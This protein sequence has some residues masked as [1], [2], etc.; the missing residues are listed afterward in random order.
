MF[1]KATAD[2]RGSRLFFFYSL[3]CTAPIH[4]HVN[5]RC[6]N[7]FQSF[8][9]VFSIDYKFDVFLTGWLLKY[10]YID[11]FWF[12]CEFV[13]R[14]FACNE[15]TV[16]PWRLMNDDRCVV[17]ADTSPSCVR[18]HG[19]LT[20]SGAAWRRN[21]QPIRRMSVPSSLHVYYNWRGR[22]G[23]SSSNLL[24]WALRRRLVSAGSVATHA[25]LF[26]SR[27]RD[28]RKDF[29]R[30]HAVPLCVD[31]WR[32]LSGR[33]R[34]IRDVT[35]VTRLQRRRSLGMC[36]TRLSACSLEH[37]HG[38]LINSLISLLLKCKS[39]LFPYWSVCPSAI[40]SMNLQLHTL[41]FWF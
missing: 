29:V 34:E 1:D 31:W 30:Q 35:H 27:P 16:L 2:N 20:C 19:L 8:A 7:L 6:Y 11:N 15:S 39:Q 41:N 40:P 25:Q 10:K 38:W 37:H 5:P 17:C 26:T 12:D 9:F 13:L 3:Q 4:W 33:R 22:P 36:S 23:Y 14:S 18:R 21:R 24:L 28:D 32:G